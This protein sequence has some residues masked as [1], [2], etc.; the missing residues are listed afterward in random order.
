MQNWISR[1]IYPSTIFN[2]IFPEYWIH[3]PRLLAFIFGLSSWLEITRMCWWTTNWVRPW[4]QKSL[5]QNHPYLRVLGPRWGAQK[6]KQKQHL[7]EVQA[8]T[9][10][11][12]CLFALNVLILLLWCCFGFLLPKLRMWWY[13]LVGKWCLFC[14]CVCLC[15]C[16]WV[17]WRWNE[18]L[19][20]CRL[21]PWWSHD[22]AVS[23]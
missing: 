18:L 21:T 14:V 2:I 1:N 12:V 17:C 9:I 10:L 19:S 11:Y 8:M 15:E 5:S 13:D 22:L 23:L 4:P 6:K 16:L 3:F 20:I 7:K